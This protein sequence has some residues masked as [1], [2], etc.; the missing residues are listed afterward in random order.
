VSSVIESPIGVIRQTPVWACPASPPLSGESPP[1]SA[2]VPASDRAGESAEASTPES[3][4]SVE[5]SAASPDELLDPDAELS[6]RPLDE[7]TDPPAEDALSGLPP[8]GLPPD[9][10]LSDELLELVSD[11]TIDAAAELAER[12]PDDPPEPLAG[13]G[14]PALDEHAANQAAGTTPQS[15]TRKTLFTMFGAVAIFSP[16]RWSERHRA[17]ARQS[18]NGSTNRR[19]RRGPRRKRPAMA[20]TMESNRAG[21]KRIGPA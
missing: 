7:P 5:A 20:M 3:S 16:R 14:V 4:R 19:A 12:P 9:E 2:E 17:D 8:D 10:L 11:A 15:T 21:R 6:E 13:S 1:P 18:S